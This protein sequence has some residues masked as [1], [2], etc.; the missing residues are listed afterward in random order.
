MFLR[1]V[2]YLIHACFEL[3]DKAGPEDTAIKFQEMFIRR[4]G[5]GQCF[6]RPYLGCREFAANFA[7]VPHDAPLPAAIEESRDLGF[8]LY[9]MDFS[10]YSPMPTWFRAQLDN[11]R[12]AVPPP[13]S[14]EV[15]R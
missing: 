10:G 9:D 1:D 11:G 7:Y 3:T 15:R 13:D 14:E 6:H 8:M 12:I 2:E 5:Q 4:A